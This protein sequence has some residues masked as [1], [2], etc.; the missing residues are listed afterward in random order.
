MEHYFINVVSAGRILTIGIPDSATIKRDMAEFRR[1]GR[2]IDYTKGRKTRALIYL[3]DGSA[4]AS[5]MLPDTLATRFVG[6]SS[7]VTKV[8]KKD[9]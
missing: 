2:L 7:A 1:A 4:I 9:A 5:T 6:R 3:D 8:G